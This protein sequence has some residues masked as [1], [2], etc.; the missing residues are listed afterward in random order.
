MCESYAE[1]THRIQFGV[2]VFVRKMHAKNDDNDD[3]DGDAGDMVET[4][5]HFSIFDLANS[6]CDWACVCVLCMCLASLFVHASLQQTSFLARLQ[7]FEQVFK[8]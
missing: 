5:F 8:T 6:A 4:N 7:T 2:Y 1:P 3:G